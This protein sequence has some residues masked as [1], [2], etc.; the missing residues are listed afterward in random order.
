MTGALSAALWSSPAGRRAVQTALLEPLLEP[1]CAGR[2]QPAAEAELTGGLT[3]AWQLLVAGSEP[4]SPCLDGL[5]PHAAAL[6][7]LHTAGRGGVSQLRTPCRELL[8]RLLRGGRL[9]DARHLVERLLL[10]EGIGE[11]RRFVPGETGGV[12]VEPIPD[13][14]ADNWLIEDDDAAAAFAA[15]L[16]EAGAPELVSDVFVALLERMRA[17]VALES[18]AEDVSGPPCSGEALL[19][20]E[21]RRSEQRRTFRHGLLTLRALAA[22]ADCEPARAGLE[23]A[24]RLVPV[25]QTLLET[26]STAGEGAEPGLLQL[27]TVCLALGVLAGLLGAEASTAPAWAAA[28]RLLPVLE[29]LAERPDG[30]ERVRDMAADLRRLVLTNGVIQPSDL[31]GK[32]GHLGTVDQQLKPDPDRRQ[33]TGQHS[34]PDRQLPSDQPVKP[35]PLDHKPGLHQNLAQSQTP[36][37]TVLSSRDNNAAT[38]TDP[39]P[40][41]A[42]VKIEPSVAAADDCL[43]QSVDGAYLSSAPV[44]NKASTVPSAPSAL[45]GGSQ[46]PAAAVTT[47]AAATSAS[48]GPAGLATYQSAMYELVDPLLPVRAHAL[49]SLSRLLERRDPETCRHREKLLTVFLVR[50]CS[51]RSDCSLM[52]ILSWMISMWMVPGRV[53]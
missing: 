36:L 21:R 6:F 31:P 42:A 23:D 47:A 19:A 30:S 40:T 51:A 18:L 28:R 41:D 9:G 37:I 7:Q 44:P 24:A 52:K 39:L 2:P 49:M 17:V 35:D 33:Q 15:L 48:D 1:L 8:H 10:T 5:V 4:D 14:E 12:R 11:R 16:G 53:M 20:W 29:R 46:Q 50:N 32:P 26:F 27:E 25:V 34:G 45:P 38:D 22:L 3:A 43:R 13:D